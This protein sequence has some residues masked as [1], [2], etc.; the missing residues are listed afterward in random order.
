[1]FGVMFS[2]Y[3]RSKRKA[4][5]MSQQQLADKLSAL[6]YKV[7]NG[8]I[9]YYETDYGQKKGWTNR[10][11]EVFIDYLADALRLNRDEARLA[12]GY[13]AQ[14]SPVP[15]EILSISFDGLTADDIKEIT[16]FIEFKK[17]MRRR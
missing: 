9:S 12:A 11:P 8:K 5:G 3:L 6:G 13:K 16:E 14:S 1:M 10:P 15:P 4:A 7:S 2:E 17:S